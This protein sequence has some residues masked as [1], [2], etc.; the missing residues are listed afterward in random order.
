ME[1]IR[2]ESAFKGVNLNFNQT[3]PTSP[4]QVTLAGWTPYTLQTFREN[5]HAF[6][7][8][9]KE[10]VQCPPLLQTREQTTCTRDKGSRESR[11]S[12]D[13]QQWHHTPSLA[14]PDLEFRFSWEK[15]GAPC[16]QSLLENPPATKGPPTKQIIN[17]NYSTAP[18]QNPRWNLHS[19]EQLRVILMIITMGLKLFSKWMKWMKTFV[20]CVG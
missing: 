11:V 14:L 20:S 13:L 10:N 4:Q 18:L 2:P 9:D 17:R 3:S 12:S 5:V 1:S 7:E 8:G 16:H 19:N 6:G 15:Q